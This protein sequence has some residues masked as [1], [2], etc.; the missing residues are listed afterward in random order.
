[1]SQKNQ[2]FNFR[3]V[4]SYLLKWFAIAASI[5]LLT[6]SAVAL[7]LWLLDVVT[8]FREAHVWIIALLPAAGYLIG[9]L[10]QY[11]GQDIEG[12]NNLLIDIIHQPGNII[13]FKM[14]PFVL[15]GTLVTHL[16][17]GSAGREG[18]ALQMAGSL[19]DVLSKP[20]RLSNNER[21]ILLIAAVSAGFGAVFGTPAAGAIFG[22]EFLRSGKIK[23]DAVLPAFAAA[24]L[25][26]AVTRMLGIEHVHYHIHTPVALNGLN[27]LYLVFA[28]IVF[29]LT[30][31]IFSRAIHKST[32]V[33]K[34]VIRRPALRPF[35]GGV[36]VAGAV[37]MIGTTKYIGLGIPFIVQSFNEQMPPYDFAVKMIF[38]I[39][40]LS[41]GFKGGEVT[42]LFFIGALLGNAL[43]YFVPLPADVLA[44]M[45][46]VAVFAGAANAPLA[47]SIMAMELFG[48]QY[49]ILA[50]IICS[51][52]YLASG[53]NSIYKSQQIEER[54]YSS[55]RR[56]R[57]KYFR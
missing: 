46:F 13:P 52:A 16:F 14:A 5:A 41:A 34:S 30:A 37:F 55:F 8:G 56:I 3:F 51:V 53:R 11:M 26:D 54:K 50:F 24:F 42:P 1:M 38:T 9:L 12:G 31:A 18:T 20:F 47:C 40:T 6:G 32:A 36:L 39:V 29:G 7:F 33:F 19:T 45:G 23:Y 49:G 22:L 43:S 57:N 15:I 28:G 4:I 27:I 2:Y 35:T 44:G 48:V 10:Y 17:G 25:A 21:S